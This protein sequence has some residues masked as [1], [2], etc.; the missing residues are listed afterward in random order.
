MV[1]FTKHISASI[2]FNS[3]SKENFILNPKKIEHQNRVRWIGGADFKTTNGVMI[4]AYSIIETDTSLNIVSH[5]D[6]LISYYIVQP[7]DSVEKIAK[8]FGVK[9]ETIIFENN[10]NSEGFLKAGQKN[11]YFNNWWIDL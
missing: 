3:V 7:G 11:C 9:Q 5:N 1:F 8:K 10:L 4:P 6:A 2:Y